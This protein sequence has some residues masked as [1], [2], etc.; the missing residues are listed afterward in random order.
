[1]LE[2]LMHDDELARN[3]IA[4]FL[5]DIPLQIQALKGY[6]ENGDQKSA[7]RQPHTIRGASANI[8]AEALQATASK[9]EKYGRQANLPAMQASLSELDLQ[10]ERLRAELQKEID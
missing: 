7:E 5:E 2:R 8:G 4:G 6:I 9:M 1:M 3:V 10:F